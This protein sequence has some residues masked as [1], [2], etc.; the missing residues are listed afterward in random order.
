[1]R[2]GR[3]SS[4]I[5]KRDETQSLILE[6]LEERIHRKDHGRYLVRV[7]L[8]TG[9]DVASFAGIIDEDNPTSGPY[10]GTSFV[11]FPGEGG[12]VV[13]L[14]VGTAGFGADTA[15]L[16]RPGHERRLRALARMHNGRL[17]VKPDLLDISTKVPDTI[18][19]RWPNID[20]AL[21]EYSSV[22]YAAVGVRQDEDDDVAAQVVSDLL[23]L[24][25]FERNIR[26]KGAASTRWQQRLE[27]I[28]SHI[29]PSVALEDVRALLCERRFVILEGPPGTCKTRL[30]LQVAREI[31]SY[32]MVQ[33]HPA[34]TY[35]DFVVGLYP[36]ATRDGLA[37]EVRPG[38][39]LRANQQAQINKHVL[40]VDEI[41]RADLGRVLGEAISLFEPGEPG[42][43]VRLPHVP[44]GFPPELQ[45]SP[46]LLV[47][48]T[49]NTADRSIAHLDLAIRRR[50][51]F[52]EM[53][54]SLAVV[55]EEDEPLAITAFE[56]VIR[57][58]TEFT[59]DEELRL[60]P[61]HSYF[62]DPLGGSHPEGRSERVRRRLQ[63]EVVPLLR[64][65]VAEHLVG[66]A[67]LE[68]KGL[69]D[70][71]ENMARD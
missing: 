16:G 70:R 26:H 60:I 21:K 13:A 6:S 68:I 34:R 28:T 8:Q 20:A 66:G 38:D 49:R 52:L 51:A 71:I 46:N 43:T 14:V 64:A 69:A 44:D 4:L 37:F 10:Q 36:S 7:N 54:P 65:Y 29:F 17:W 9:A 25:L 55:R 47:L 57:T 40:V 23:D 24:Y 3:E 2:A 61:G 19:Q 22:I 32:E 63:L 56:D 11:W 27:E 42:R 59:T 62:L 41:N 45:L 39:L 53:W 67:S 31:G 15:I 12:S 50:F 33:F 48:G 35:E 1:M 30:A 18:T 58:F 5:G